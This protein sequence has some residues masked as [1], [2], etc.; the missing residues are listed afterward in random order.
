MHKVKWIFIT[1]VMLVVTAGLSVCAYAEDIK[2]GAGGAP[3]ENIFKPIKE[4][5]EKATGIKLNIVSSGPKNAL[6]DLDKNAVDAAAAGLSFQDWLNMMKKEGQEVKDPSA[7]QPVVIGKDRMI[8]IV[9]KENKVKSL[10]DKQ[11]EGIFSGETANWKDVGGDDSPILV[12]LGKLTP[13]TN[14]TFAKKFL[15]GKSFPKEVLDATSADD[16]K[17][18]V[19]ANPSAIAFGPLALT[20]GSVKAIETTELARDITLLTKGK[21]SPKVQKLIDFIKREGQKYVK[22]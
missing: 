5:F 19:A 13:G 3:T 6:L 11:L 9:H 17:Q 20:D 22:Q 18:N 12:V 21:A 4:A 1:A 15:G 14:S 2:I 16:V 7:Y 8:V 10:T